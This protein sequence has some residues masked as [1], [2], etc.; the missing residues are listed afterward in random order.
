MKLSRLLPLAVCL[1]A[2][3]AP[4]SAQ[5][6]IPVLENELREITATMLAA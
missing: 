3:G 2:F 4:A 5:E 6:K 1:V